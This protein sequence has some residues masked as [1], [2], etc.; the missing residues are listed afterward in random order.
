MDWTG[1]DHTGI[2]LSVKMAS[3]WLRSDAR[4]VLLWF[5]MHI[6]S[7]Y[8]HNK[9]SVGNVMEIHSLLLQWFN[10]GIITDDAIYPVFIQWLNLNK[11][12]W[13]DHACHVQFIWADHGCHAQLT[14][15]TWDSY[16]WIS[17]YHF[18]IYYWSILE[19]IM[20]VSTVYDVWV[21][22]APGIL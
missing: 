10:K 5:T 4:K 11:I 12:V 19:L 17:I 6:Y 18:I 14:P 16:H 7:T 13:A 1:H 9:F 2:F 22:P 15:S 3:V 20:C 21:W 8:T